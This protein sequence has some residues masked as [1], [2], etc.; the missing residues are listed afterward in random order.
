MYYKFALLKLLFCLSLFDAFG[1]S[2][3]KLEHTVLT[4]TYEDNT[5]CKFTLI[6]ASFFN[7][8][9]LLLTDMET[10][11]S[12][13]IKNQYT[14]ATEGSGYIANIVCNDQGYFKIL[15]STGQLSFIYSDQT[16]ITSLR[17][18]IKQ[19][20][21]NVQPHFVNGFEIYSTPIKNNNL[22]IKLQI[23]LQEGQASGGSITIKRF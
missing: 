12:A 15:K 21:P 2:E 7:L 23:Y 18:E 19:L 4:F 5:T 1:Q 20:Y 3:L 22:V 6:S 14:L 9:N 10:F 13:M 11:R 16:G 17:N 8:K